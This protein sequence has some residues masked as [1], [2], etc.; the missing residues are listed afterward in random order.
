MADTDKI[1]LDSLSPEE[2]KLYE[3]YGRLPKQSQLLAKKDKKYFDS[4]DWAKGQHDAK[5][6]V[7]QP[8]KTIKE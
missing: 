4:A 5:A 6:E 2:K 1:N 3:K 7:K 8:E